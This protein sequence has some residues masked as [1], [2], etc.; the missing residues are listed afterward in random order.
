MRREEKKEGGERNWREEREREEFE[1]GRE[2]GEMRRE[3][4][5]KSKIRGMEGD[6]E[7]GAKRREGDRTADREVG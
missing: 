2:T 6:R 7:M 5:E 4:W 3:K 1:G